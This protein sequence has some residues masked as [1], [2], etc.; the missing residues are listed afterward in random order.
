M[1][2]KLGTDCA[3][4]LCVHT[5]C[6]KSEAHTNGDECHEEGG[7]EEHMGSV[8]FEERTVG[9]RCLELNKKP[10]TKNTL[11]NTLK[12]TKYSVVALARDNA[13]KA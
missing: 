4:S 11:N 6:A 9:H 12:T 3:G 2:H 10:S 13:L 1:E 5:I 7:G 8:P